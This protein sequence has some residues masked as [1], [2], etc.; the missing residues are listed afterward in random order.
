MLNFVP[1]Y[2]K[3]CQKI[4][5][6]LTCF[7][8]SI[9]FSSSYSSERITSNNCVHFQKIEIYHHFYCVIQLSLERTIIKY[10]WLSNLQTFRNPS[11]DV[12]SLLWLFPYLSTDQETLYIYNDPNDLLDHLSALYISLCH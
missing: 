2:M 12:H 4:K 1:K 6:N 9:Y 3:R 11:E 5:Q 7:L 8:L 10:L